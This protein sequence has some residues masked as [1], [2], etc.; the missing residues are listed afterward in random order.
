MTIEEIQAVLNDMVQA[1]QGKGIVAPDADFTLRAQSRV[2][3]GL[4]CKVSNP[5]FD[6]EYLKNFLGETP[7]QALSDAAAYIATLPDPATEGQRKYTRKLA[8]AVDIATEYALPDAAIAP[9]RAAIREVNAVL[10]PG[11]A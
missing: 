11:P 9:V 7:A 1:M 4:W 8:E 6:G 10:L 3:V 5:Q 2:S